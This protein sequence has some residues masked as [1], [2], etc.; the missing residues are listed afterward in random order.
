MDKE[1]Q[2][3]VVAVYSK[4][5]NQEIFEGSAFFAS[6]MHLLTAK[7]VV[8]DSNRNEFKK[9]LCLKILHDHERWNVTQSNIVFHENPDV[10][11]ALITLAGSVGLHHLNVSKIREGVRGEIVDIC[12]I[13]KESA[14]RAPRNNH[15]LSTYDQGLGGYK[16]DHQVVRGYS[17]GLVAAGES[18][19]G[20]VIQRH[21]EDQISLALPLFEIK[22]WLENR[23][24]GNLTAT[25][26][27]GE[28]YVY[29][30]RVFIDRPKRTCQ[31]ILDSLDDQPVSGFV[32]VADAYDHHEPR[33][34]GRT[35][36]MR[37]SAR[38]VENPYEKLLDELRTDRL[39]APSLGVD[40]REIESEAQF[41]SK[42]LSAIYEE[43]SGVQSRESG[44]MS[45][46]DKQTAII[47]HMR[48]SPTPRIFLLYKNL[49]SVGLLQKLR[50]QS[51]SRQIQNFAK[52]ISSW[53]DRWRN[54]R[55]DEP[56]QSLIILLMIDVDVQ[57]ANL[58]R[59]QQKEELETKKSL[60]LTQVE[61]E[62]FNQWLVHTKRFLKLPAVGLDGDIDRLVEQAEKKLLDGLEGAKGEGFPLYYRRFSQ[63]CKTLIS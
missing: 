20:I 14:S 3:S 27:S 37:V 52:W 17:G 58:Y 23:I 39:A 29:Q 46:K 56:M 13:D 21:K 10:D 51:A 12:G 62:D 7:H 57:T 60:P 59:M 28:E 11:V 15:T 8:Y 40:F 42:L 53:N 25:C 19:I 32:C 26:V 33:E 2:D 5:D 44:K 9:G 47:E 45:D 61:R 55:L 18:P 6:S 16:L 1:L 54:H 30:L 22:D 24:G 36:A 35:L 63:V 49:T 48:G 31:V 4:R 43:L 34:F 41:H 38:S 50:G